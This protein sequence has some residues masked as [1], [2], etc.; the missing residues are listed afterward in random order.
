MILYL[1]Q[2]HRDVEQI[3]AF[4][5]HSSHRGCAYLL[6]LD[7]GM[8]DRAEDLRSQIAARKLESV[9]VRIG[10]PVAWGGISQVHA[11]LDALAFALTMDEPWDHLINLSADSI[12]LAPQAGIESFYANA[13]RNGQR[14]HLSYFGSGVRLSG[15]SLLDWGGAEGF[16]ARA[17]MVDLYRRVPAL[18]DSKVANLIGER[19]TS[20]L[21][22]WRH[23]CGIHVTDLVLEKKLV[24]RSLLPLEAEYRIRSFGKR[25]LFGGRAWYTL[26][27]S[28]IEDMLSDPFLGEVV[29]ML[30]HF[31]CPDE[32]F[33]QT[34]FM[35]GDR[36]KPKEIDREN[37]RFR[38]GDAVAIRDEMAE[39]LFA[40]GAFFARKVVLRNCPSLRSTLDMMI[41]E[42]DESAGS[43]RN[44]PV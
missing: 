31:F 26:A 15:F 14:V 18:V 11:F 19:S 30:E 4:L 39:E 5:E 29:N 34:Y 28:A 2:A 17:E 20:P 43:S 35:H 38:R 12:A 16:D 24:M 41:Q 37:Q 7:P 25:L 3:L 10:V 32:L 8:R 36:F 22:R 13:L 1:V 42:Q 40:S 21:F 27:R 33:L 44:H 23:R 9:T 6:N